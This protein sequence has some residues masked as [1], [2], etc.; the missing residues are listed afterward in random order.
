MKGF[1]TKNVANMDMSRGANVRNYVL[2]PQADSIWKSYPKLLP[3]PNLLKSIA[4][5]THGALLVMAQ[6]KPTLLKEWEDHLQFEGPLNL[7]TIM[8]ETGLVAEPFNG[9][10]VEGAFTL[11]KQG[12][13]ELKILKEAVAAARA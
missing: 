12:H 9:G 2:F 13:P 5:A 10:E 4:A 8:Q 3:Y 6:L 7:A 11:R 1:S